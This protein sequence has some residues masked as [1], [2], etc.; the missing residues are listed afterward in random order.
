MFTDSATDG[1]RTQIAA[2]W[3]GDDHRLLYDQDDIV[4]VYRYLGDTEEDTIEVTQAFIE[5]ARNEMLA[6]QGESVDSGLL[7]AGEP[8]VWIDRTVDELLFIAAT[9][10]E[11]GAQVRALVAA[12]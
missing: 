12:G 4:F 9:D 11:L 10:A 3:G 7:F 8:Y 6:G 2:G 5:L 1:F